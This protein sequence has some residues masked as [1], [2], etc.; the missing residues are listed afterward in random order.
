MTHSAGSHT[1]GEVI[2]LHG[3]TEGH[4][5]RGEIGSSA[6]VHLGSAVTASYIWLFTEFGVDVN[7]TLFPLVESF[8]M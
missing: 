6:P 5:G 4:Q 1:I 7:C 2:R 8:K 3:G